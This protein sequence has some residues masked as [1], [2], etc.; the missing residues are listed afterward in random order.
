MKRW[1]CGVA[2][3]DVRILKNGKIFLRYHVTTRRCERKT[4][5][6][7]AKDLIGCYGPLF[8]SES[9]QN[10]ITTL[11]IGVVLK[12]PRTQSCSL[13]SCTVEPR[14]NDTNFS[15]IFLRYTEVSFNQ[16]SRAGIINKEGPP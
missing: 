13:D 14:Y 11:L 8:L 9:N 10:F 4:V 12:E 6:H 5:C 15:A 3:K 1:D 2:F 16:G 7:L